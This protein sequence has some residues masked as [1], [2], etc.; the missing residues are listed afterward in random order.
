MVS[1]PARS[2]AQRRPLP[3]SESRARRTVHR[4]GAAHRFAGADGIE[5]DRSAVADAHVDFKLTTPRRSSAGV[6]VVA[7]ATPASSRPP[8][9]ARKT[10]PLRHG[11]PAPSHAHAQHHRLHQ[12]HA[13][14]LAT[15]PGFSAGGMSNRMNNVQIDGATERDV[16]GLG[17][18]GAPGAEVNAKSLSIEAVKEFQVLLAPFDVRQGNFGGC[19]STRSR[20]AARTT[21]TARCSTLPQPELRR[22]H[23]GRARTA[24][25]SLADRLLARRPD[26]P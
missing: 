2:D 7:T 13:A 9:P 25:Q 3:R 8:T 21:S 19:C 17:S 12:A 22:R 6:Q 1:R 14:G 10:T 18:T 15:G 5:P 26:H 4:H 20:R 11:P 23:A 16:F 24:V